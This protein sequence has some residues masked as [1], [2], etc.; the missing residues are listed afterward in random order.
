MILKSC[1]RVVRI[2]FLADKQKDVVSLILATDPMVFSRRT[3]SQ[4]EDCDRESAKEEEQF[5]GTV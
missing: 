5:R 4:S 2:D 1:F 3:V